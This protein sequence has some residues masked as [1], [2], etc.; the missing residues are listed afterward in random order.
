MTD[1]TIIKVRTMVSPPILSV[2]DL[3]SSSASVRW[4]TRGE[5]TGYSLT[6]HSNQFAESGSKFELSQESD[7]ISFDTLYPSTSYTITLETFTGQSWKMAYS[8]KILKLQI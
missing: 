4:T 7:A 6:L 3:R 2:S 5:Y 1:E 8:S